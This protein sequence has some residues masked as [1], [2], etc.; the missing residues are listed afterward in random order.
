MES[1][2]TNSLETILSKRVMDWIAYSLWS[3]IAHGW[4]FSSHRKVEQ[5][6]LSIAI[7]TRNSDYDTYNQIRCVR[8]ELH[9]ALIA[10][11]EGKAVNRQY[12][13]RIT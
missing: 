1:A 8:R 4:I 9:H 2:I 12:I 7:V 6:T 11:R 10:T 5:M 13:T 3:R